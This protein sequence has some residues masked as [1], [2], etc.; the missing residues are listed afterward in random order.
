MSPSSPSSSSRPLGRPATPLDVLQVPR[1]R[2]FEAVC[3]Q[4]R[5]K[6]R[7]GELAPGDRLPGDAE[8]AEMFNVNRNSV[9]EALRSLEIAGVVRSTTGVQGGFFIA[10]GRN[11]SLKQA[12]RDMVAV[13]SM[14][15][16]S[17]TEA[18]IM[19][20]VQAVKLAV[21]RGTAQDFDAI[22][23]DIARLETIA[24]RDG[25]S[26]GTPQLTAFYR[27]LAE[28]T[29]NEVIVVLV[30]GLSDIVRTLIARTH[31]SVQ[32]DFIGIRRS[33]LRHM[34]AGNEA[35]AVDII[36]R[37]LTKMHA[38]LEQAEA[39]AEVQAGMAATPLRPAA[40]APAARKS[41]A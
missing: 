37:H 31:P 23:A 34:R 39:Q 25:L 17:L 3:E 8:L 16:A 18:R 6:I 20:V 32:P 9:R 36:T 38:H 22:E 2:A 7:N 4:I 30:E 19:V 24:Q 12:M 29:H 21:Q 11:D 13:G 1:R 10:E 33:I 27:L 35:K 5:A 15:P 41:K 14:R 40:R 28:A 26:H